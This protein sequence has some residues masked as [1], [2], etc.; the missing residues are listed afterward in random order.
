MKSAG[1]GAGR[2]RKFASYFRALIETG[3]AGSGCAGIVMTMVASGL[4]NEFFFFNVELFFI[5]TLY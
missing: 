4:M 5:Y 2:D 3:G 1:W